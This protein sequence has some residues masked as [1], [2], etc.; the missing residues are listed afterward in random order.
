MKQILDILR[1]FRSRGLDL[2]A[3]LVAAT[4]REGPLTAKDIEEAVKPAS[5]D[6]VIRRLGLLQK[7]ALVERY[8]PEDGDRRQPLYRLTRKGAQLLN[9]EPAAA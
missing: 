5:Y 7:L 1:G 3:C 9:P 6:A 2:T 8:H 4:L